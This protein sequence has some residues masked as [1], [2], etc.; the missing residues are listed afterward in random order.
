MS[1][2][3][4]PQPGGLEGLCFGGEPLQANDYP[5]AEPKDIG[6]ISF[7]PDVTTAPDDCDPRFDDGSRA[8]GR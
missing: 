7:D 6:L 1:E 5:V 3:L 4:L 8:R 2:R